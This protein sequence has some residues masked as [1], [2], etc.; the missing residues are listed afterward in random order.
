[1]SK[2]KE[3]RKKGKAGNKKK[4]ILEKSPM[5]WTGKVNGKLESKD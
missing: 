1:M 3:L 5:R 2:Q 4:N